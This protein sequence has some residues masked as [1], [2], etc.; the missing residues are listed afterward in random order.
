LAAVQSLQA[1]ASS[2][3][4]ELVSHVSP[5]RGLRYGVAVVLFTVVFAV[6][7]HAVVVHP[8]SRVP[9]CAGDGTVALREMWVERAQHDNPLTFTRDPFNGAPEGLSRS[10][11]TTIAASALQTAF[12]WGLKGVVGDVGAW[13][14]FLAL[15]LVGSALAMFVLL[16][17]LGCTVVA[18]LFGGFVFG[19]GP[20][21][22]ER[23]YAGHRARRP[24]S[25]PRRAASQP[26]KRGRRGS[27]ARVGVLDERL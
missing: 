12:V 14:L 25:D 23:A 19:F 20:Y 9:C 11:A 24:G 4:G 5:S 21:A 7:F 27:G 22:L 10:P 2:S 18:S 26:R 15:G 8:A 17:R 3:S 13:N 1:P 6:W 16:Q